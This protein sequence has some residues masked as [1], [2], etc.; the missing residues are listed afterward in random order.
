VERPRT[1]D[2]WS[3]NDP[4]II[5]LALVAAAVMIVAARLSRGFPLGSPVRIGL[6]L[7]QGA[8]SAWVIVSIVRGIRGLDELQQKIQLEALAF[9][10]AGTGLLA[11]AYGFLVNAGLPDIDWGTLVWPAMTALWAIGVLLASRRYR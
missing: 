8:A 2:T 3:C 7:V 10:F 1:Q 4:R 5:A 9:A 11:S 6:A